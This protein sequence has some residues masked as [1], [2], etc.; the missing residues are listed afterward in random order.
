F[1]LL[2]LLYHHSEFT[3]PGAKNML[4]ATRLCAPEW[5]QLRSLEKALMIAVGDDFFS[6]LLVHLDYF[7]YV[8]N[9][10][11]YLVHLQHRTV[12]DMDDVLGAID[13]ELGKL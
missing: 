8:L 13:A 11:S 7:L 6:D 9:L 4:V 5:T 3:Q 12:Y 2:H 10:L 1:R